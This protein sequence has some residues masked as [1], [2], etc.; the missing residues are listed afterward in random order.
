MRLQFPLFVAALSLLG[1]GCGSRESIVEAGNSTQTLHVASVG[2]PSELDP[3]VINAP[4][5]FKI[6]PML[7][8]SLVIAHPAT[9]EP[10]PGVASSWQVSSD[11]RRY[12]FHL[13][14][15]AQWSNGDPVTSADFLYSWRRALSPALGSQYTFLFFAVTGATDFAAG[16]NPDFQSV[17][18][19]APD[20]HTVVVQLDHPTPYFLAIIANNPVWAPVHQATVEAAGSMTD[21]GSGWTKPESF[22]GNGPFTLTDWKPNEI[23]R[24][25]KSPTYW[26]AHA[27]RLHAV[28]YHAYDSG[29]TEE[30]SFRAQQL[31]RTERVPVAKLPGYR[32]QADSPLRE[33]PSLIST[34]I[35]FNT[36][37]P[38]FDDE[39]V[40]RAFALAIDREKLAEVVYLRSAT[41]ARRVV[42]DG[43]TG[44]PEED[45]FQ[46]DATAAQAL[47]ASAG[48]PGGTGFPV[49]QLS[50]ESGR[51]QDLPQAL[52]A[53]WREVLG[54][55]IE[56][57]ASESRVHWSSLQ[58]G[59]FTLATGGWIADYPDA[60][61]FLDLWKTDSGWN[62]TGWNSA[63]YD[64]A[65]TTAASVSDPTVRVH[66]LR[67]AE[68]MLMQAM[69]VIPIVFPKTTTLVHPSVH[70]FE[71]NAMDRPDYRTVILR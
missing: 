69:P 12:T 40:R 70:D 17:G 68:R 42:P 56:I 66:L 59:N 13:R 51:S 27:V 7:F 57:V 20:A 9:L 3:H 10:M 18:F 50:I 31:H 64:A 22:V 39:R 58:Q 62:F 52:Q 15:D 49:T 55:P 32:Q 16:R 23:I 24:I 43:I 54:V 26:N 29:D 65:L 25:E 48:Y 45:D 47:L 2:E 36:T 6:V 5:D 46:D 11:L 33:T 1:T 4:P 37:R 38:P 67:D 44:Y 63:N 21:R 71:D 34:F 19:A 60:T 28:V 35:N 61:A 41:P 14:L 30:R 53:R 8:E